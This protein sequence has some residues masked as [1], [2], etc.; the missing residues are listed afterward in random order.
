MIVQLA[1]AFSAGAAVTCLSLCILRLLSGV[2]LERKRAA[3]TVQGEAPVAGAT[4][5][6][7]FRTRCKFAT[8]RCAHEMPE[9]R[10]VEPGHFAACHNLEQMGG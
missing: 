4:E 6:C 5:G 8:E 1:A 10:E 3:E 9:L 7:R 2:E